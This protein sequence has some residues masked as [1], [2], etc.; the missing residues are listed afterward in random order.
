MNRSDLQSLSRERLNEA[1][2]LLDGGFASGAY[3]LAG[4]A[5]EFALKACI[6][7]QTAQYDFPDKDKANAS[8]RHDLERLSETANLSAKL[9]AYAKANTSFDANWKIAQAW[10]EK[11][12]Y[13]PVSDHEAKTLIEAL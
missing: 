12:R 7:K 10:N 8:F 11:S 6:A 5:A 2:A 4:Y 9:V 3:Y 1:R 13:R